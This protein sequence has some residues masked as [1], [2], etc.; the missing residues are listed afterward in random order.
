MLKVEQMLVSP[1]LRSRV[2]SVCLTSRPASGIPNAA[3]RGAVMPYEIDPRGVAWA[4]R[5]MRTPGCSPGGATDGHE[6]SRV[7][8]LPDDCGGCRVRP[9]SWRERHPGRCPAT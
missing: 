7:G 9:F 8:E 1:F 5:R 2:A 4:T 6:A 3:S